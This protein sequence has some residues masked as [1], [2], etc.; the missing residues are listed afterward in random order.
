MQSI[1]TVVVLPAPLG[2]RNPN[3]SPAVTVRSMSR[4]ASIPSLNVRRSERAAMDTSA[5]VGDATNLSL[6]L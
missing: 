4:T 5:V 1:R 6:E 3:T 2:P